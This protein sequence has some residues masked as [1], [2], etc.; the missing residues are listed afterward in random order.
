M[1]NSCSARAGPA[2]S[3]TILIFFWPAS[4][5]QLRNCRW[6]KKIE[7]ATAERH[8]LGSSK[9]SRKKRPDSSSVWCRRKERGAINP[10]KANRCWSDWNSGSNP[11]MPKFI[12]FSCRI[13]NPEIRQLTA[14]LSA[15][16]QLGAI[17]EKDFVPTISF[18]F[19]VR[20]LQGGFKI[21][22]IIAETIFPFACHLSYS[23][24]TTIIS[25]ALILGSQVA[26]AESLPPL[27][28]YI[29]IPMVHKKM[30]LLRFQFP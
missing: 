25:P 13:G 16:C 4:A 19:L 9:G 1:E 10:N 28:L 14:H 18:T 12:L 3:A 20:S 23:V 2:A 22:S 11:G 6:S 7:S 17:T 15:R 27:S 8:S 5:K 26:A 29:H 21:I 24:M 30:P